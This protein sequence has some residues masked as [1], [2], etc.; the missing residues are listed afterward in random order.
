MQRDQT[1]YSRARLEAAKLYTA[2]Q[3]LKNMQVQW[4]ALDYGNNLEAGEGVNEGLVGSDIGAV[5]FATADE[6][7]TR[8]LETGHASNLAKLL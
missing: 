2:I 4:N 8:L 5:V 3:N 6:A 7:S 1:Y